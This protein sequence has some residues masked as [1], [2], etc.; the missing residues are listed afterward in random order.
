MT[1]HNK[2]VIEVALKISLFLLRTNLPVCQAGR[3]I[4]SEDFAIEICGKNK[5]P[6]ESNLWTL[7]SENDIE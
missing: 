2:S 1:D 4:A 6:G 7:F 5:F 3:K